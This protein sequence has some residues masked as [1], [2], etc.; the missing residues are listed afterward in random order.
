MQLRWGRTKSE[1]TRNTNT[2]AEINISTQ[3]LSELLGVDMDAAEDKVTIEQLLKEK[4]NPVKKNT[5]EQRSWTA[6]LPIP[7]FQGHSDP[8]T[9]NE[10]ID[11]VTRFGSSQ[12]L[13]NEQLLHRVIPVALT[14]HAL[15]WWTF[16]GGFETWNSFVKAF[17]LEFGAT[18]YTIL[19]RRE[20]EART[21]HP[22]EPLSSFVQAIAGYYDKIGDATTEEEKINRVCRQ[23]HP[24]F[25]RLVDPKKFKTLK[26][27]ASAGPT[28][29]AEILQDRMYRPPPPADYSVEP[30]LAW[31]GGD[32]KTSDTEVCYVSTNSSPVKQLSRDFRSLGLAALD[33]FMFSHVPAWVPAQEQLYRGNLPSN[34]TTTPRSNNLCYICGS[35]FH[36]ARICPDRDNQQRRTGTGQKNY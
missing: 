16:S 28:I 3:L 13:N 30:T 11:E 9:P 14:K 10:F 18:N 33:P 23:L 4:L 25:R 29:Q 34:Q 24:E 22:D 17:H 19:L 32:K 6:K 5:E 12:G 36:Y 15:R 21:Q 7:S 27:L 26:E 20:L 8:K 1:A 2:M 35:R 31:G